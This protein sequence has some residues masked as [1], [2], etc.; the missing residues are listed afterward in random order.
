MFLGLTVDCARCHDHKL[1]PI[2]QKDYYRFLSFFRNVNGYRNGGPTDEVA[3]FPNDAARL[4]FEA[5][6]RA[7]VAHRNELQ[8]ALTA[9]ETE[10]RTGYAQT[11]AGSLAS[12]D[13]D[14]LKYRYYRDTWTTLPDFDA[15]KPEEI[16]SLPDGLFDIGKRTR[17]ASIGFVFEGALVVPTAGP[18][19]FTLDSDDGSRLTVAGQTLLTRDGI[20]GEGNPQTAS[21]ELAPGRVPI[22]LDYFQAMHGLGLQVTWSGPDFAAR[23]LATGS[24]DGKAPKRGELIRGNFAKIFRRDGAGVVGKAKVAQYFELRKELDKLKRQD[25]P[26]DRAL[27]VTEV[28]RD[29]LATNVLLRGNPHNLGDPVEPA[30]LQVVSTATPS[31]SPPAPESKT[32]GRRLALAEWI[33]SPSNPL[34]ARVMAN[35]IWQYHFG[36][37]IARSSSNLGTQ[38]DKPTH[39]EL[40][41]WLAT[42]LIRDEW[43]LKPLHRTIMLSEAYQM[44]SRTDPAALA[45]DPTNDQFWRFD[46]RRLTSEEIRDS[47]LAVTGQLSDRMYGP[48]VFPEIPDEVKAGQSVPGAGWHKSSPEE[49]HRRSIYVH[50]K[51]SLLLPILE[52]F[53]QAET[54][55]SSPVR[56]ATTQPTQ[57][58]GMINGSFLNEQAHALATRL[59]G[60]AGSDVAAQVALALR[61]A[62]GREPGAAEIHR[63]VG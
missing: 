51:R 13:I 59:R 1:D 45:I 29:P 40:I 49:Q 52:S 35:R 60:D 53:D 7:L 14:D 8:A 58:L 16:G 20:H 6:H 25:V 30:F 21:V 62:T 10:F 15:L 44:S 38:G 27:V 23:P 50:V 31:L 34:T 26:A 22:R 12:V 47:I 63:G 9:I 2:P 42:E 28:G 4:K 36:R 5:D 57:A 33:T 46:M 39:P 18:Y 24:P 48:G 55:R 37:G 32:T 19:T 11:Q 54:D 3:F 43:R 56:F 61:L 17:D 41:D